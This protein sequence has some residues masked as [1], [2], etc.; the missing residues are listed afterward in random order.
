MS[1]FVIAALCLVWHFVT[2]KRLSLWYGKIKIKIGGFIVLYRN[3]RKYWREFCLPI[4]LQIVFGD[5]SL[6][7]NLT[8]FNFAGFKHIRQNFAGSLAIFPA[9][10]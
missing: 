9:V 2:L 8:G 7:S 1:F 5:F 10:R 4:S 6:V 3:S